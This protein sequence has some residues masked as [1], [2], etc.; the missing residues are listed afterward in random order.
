MDMNMEIT[1]NVHYIGVNDRTTQLFEALWPLPAGVSY[2]SYLVTGSE[3][4]A[5]IDGVELTHAAQ[6]IE[7]IKR[8]LGPG[9]KPDYLV[10]N[11]MEPDHSGAI[12]V[13][14]REWPE[15]II[16]G[17]AQTLRMVKGF[18]GAEG[19]T[20]AV[21]DGDTLPL[22]GATLRFALTP[23][24]HWPETMMTLVEEQGVLFSG[25]AFGC[26]GALNG[27]VVDR[28]MDCDR[29]FPEMVR[30]Y[31]CIVGRYGRF[32]QRALERLKDVDIKM[33]CPTHGP[34]WTER[35]AE[36]TAL[37]D[38]LSRY[39]AL[40]DGVAVVYGSMYGHTERMAEAIAGELARQGVRNI[41][42]LN[43]SHTTL[44]VILAAAFRHKGLAVVAPTY[45]DG[46]FPPVAH[47]LEALS[48]RC[49]AGRK[50]ILAGSHT[51]A[52]KAVPAM[53]ELLAG[54]DLVE[55]AEPVKALQAPD[56][57]ALEACRESARAL[58]AALR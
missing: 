9:R 4:T 21:R 34:V 15:L 35:A 49:L 1:D 26:F 5:I 23:M 18:Y 54:C 16:T 11:H 50:V 22:G 48:V 53:K 36:V 57:D 2:N 45:S 28:E 47:A 30:Y 12:E 55:V 33:L 6:Q 38:R 51:W 52:H 40:D 32:V 44:D 46:L 19:S 27:A 43:A 14:R 56:D 25:D 39:E 17:N 10:I 13:L 8:A 20:L 29:Y 37:Y 31:A 3:A 42:V 58:A 41:E 7:A 24:V